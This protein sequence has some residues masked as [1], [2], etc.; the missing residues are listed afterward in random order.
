MS[1]PTIPSRPVCGS[2]DELLR[3]MS[4]LES[5]QDAIGLDNAR[6]LTKLGDA[7]DG[8]TT[9]PSGITAILLSMQTEIS[10]QRRDRVK[11]DSLVDAADEEADTQI[12][13]KIARCSE[14]EAKLERMRSEKEDDKARR[15]AAW[16]K[17]VATILIALATGAGGGGLVRDAAAFLLNHHTTVTK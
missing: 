13:S 2:H 4:D 3:R 7:G 10:E 1:P 11:L 12:R 14:L 16:K 8:V 6:I 17:T 15:D 5:R 9:H